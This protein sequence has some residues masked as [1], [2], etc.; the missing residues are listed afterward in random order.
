[1]MCL[2]VAKFLWPATWTAWPRSAEFACAVGRAA[3]EAMDTKEARW[4]ELAEI[5]GDL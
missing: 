3:Q 1:M 5:A 2:A 4:L